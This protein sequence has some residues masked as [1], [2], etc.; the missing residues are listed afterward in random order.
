MLHSILLWYSAFQLVVGIQTVLGKDIPVLS[1]L[2]I[3]FLGS[4]LYY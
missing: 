2:I 4:W 3:Q 1:F